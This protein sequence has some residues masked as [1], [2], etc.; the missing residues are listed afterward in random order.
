MKKVTILVGS[1]RN[2][3]SLYLAKEISGKHP[4]DIIQISTKNITMCTGCLACD[5]TKKCVYTDNMD[6][7]IKNIVET[8]VVIAITPTRWGLMSGDLKLFIDRLNPI[9][10]TDE[11]V[12][13]QFIAVAIGQSETGDS[14]IHHAINSLSYFA[15]SAGMELCGSFPIFGCLSADDLSKNNDLV[16]KTVSDIIKLI[17]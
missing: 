7:L 17:I 16:T 4:V 14:S 2:G 3:N 10:T 5:E 11:L 1:A 12:G 9:A 6:E 15:E 8:D 13:K